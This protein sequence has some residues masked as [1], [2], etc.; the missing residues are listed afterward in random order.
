MA[1][2]EKPMALSFFPIGCEKEKEGRILPFAKLSDDVITLAVFKKAEKGD[3]FVI[4][5]FNPTAAERKTVLSI[6]SIGFEKEFTLGLYEFKT[7]R[8]DPRTKTVT[9]TDLT[10]R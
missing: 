3:D 9:E 4:R 5:L 6:P 7:V 10:E 2:A 8:I 1:A